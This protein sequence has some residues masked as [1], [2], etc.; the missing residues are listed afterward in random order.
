MP[1]HLTLSSKREIIK[2]HIQNMEDQQ[3]MKHTNKK[4]IKHTPNH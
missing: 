3:I 4:D 1:N 2:Y